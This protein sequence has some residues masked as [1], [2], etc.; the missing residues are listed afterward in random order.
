MN[1]ALDDDKGCL[2]AHGPGLRTF[3]EFTTRPKRH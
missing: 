2:S 1:G 3:K